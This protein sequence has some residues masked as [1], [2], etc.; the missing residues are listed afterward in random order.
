MSLS[1]KHNVK[2]IK[3]GNVFEIKEWNSIN[4]EEIPEIREKVM[5][6]DIFKFTCEHCNETHNIIYNCLY[7][8]KTG[9]FMIQLLPGFEANEYIFS[10][11]V[12]TCSICREEK[13]QKG[14]RLGMI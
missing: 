6:G 13:K 1:E 9:K 2:C 4:V 8:D 3:C 12:Q 14:A 5:N 10:H 7:Y 11:F